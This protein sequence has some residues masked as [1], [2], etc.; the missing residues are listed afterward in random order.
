MTARTKNM[1]KGKK[2]KVKKEEEP[3]VKPK[4]KVKKKEEPGSG[5]NKDSKK[6]SQNNTT[7]EEPL[8]PIDK[9]ERRVKQ[10]IIGQ[11][12]QVRQIIT[13]VYRSKVF[14]SIKANVLIIGNSGTGK[15]ATVKKIAE[16]LGLPCIIE[17]ATKYTQEGYYGAD[18]EDM[19]YKLLEDA[20]GDLERAA[21]GI[22]AIDEIDKKS[23]KGEEHDP[24]GVEVLNSL[25]K[26][27]E[28]TVL[29]IDPTQFMG[30]MV[31]FNTENL[32]ILLMGAFPGLDR[33]RDMR[34]NR[35]GFG[36][37]RTQP[38]SNGE[39][40]YTKQDLIKY[41]I[42]E[43]FAGRIDTIIEMNSLGIPEL[44]RILTDSKL[45]IFRNYEEE[46]EKHGVKLKYDDEIFDII[47][48]KALEVKTGARELRCIVNKMFEEVLFEVLANPG[49][50]R[51]CTLQN[52]I[53]DDNTKFV[54][55]WKSSRNTGIGEYSPIPVFYKNK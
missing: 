53:V 22:I 55:S 18:V 44:T 1:S 11:D 25:L 36:F 15:T 33:I 34:L 4:K 24:A 30:E 3:K 7:Q 47:A 26:I 42:P 50:Y 45:S 27:V 16:M 48:N 21:N 37:S 6:E 35:N 52:G 46:F 17:D 28:G 20:E 12:A 14:K 29:S 40:G 43:E 32:T 51:Y 2:K 41:G 39:E 49:K 10:Y 5:R 31:P 13:A 54:L 19:I 9:L 8:I 38:V 23:R